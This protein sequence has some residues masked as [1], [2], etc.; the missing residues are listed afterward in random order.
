MLMVC[1]LL[2][3]VVVDVVVVVVV[4]VIGDVDSRKYLTLQFRNLILSQNDERQNDE[5][6]CRY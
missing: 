3:F 4:L 6:L 5:T 2:F 1:F